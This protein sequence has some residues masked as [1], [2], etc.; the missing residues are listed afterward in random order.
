MLFAY[1]GPDTMMPLTSVVAAVFGVSLMF[2][3]QVL[4]LLSLGWSQVMRTGRPSEHGPM[5]SGVR[6]D[7]AHIRAARTASARRRVE[8]PDNDATQVLS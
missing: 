3:R 8:A 6:L 2:G 4:R 5:Q 7:V 1:L